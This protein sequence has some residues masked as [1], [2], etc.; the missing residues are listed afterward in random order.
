[1][2]SS[3]SPAD[4]LRAYLPDDVSMLDASQSAATLGQ[5]KAARGFLDAYEARLT[6]HL[7]RLHKAGTSAPA[8]DLHT[9][10]GGVSS[11]EAKAKERRAAAL[12]HAPSMAEKLAAGEIT[13]S[14]ADRLAD[15]TSR[16]DDDTRAAFFAHDELLAHDASRRTPEEFARNCRDL[17]RSIERDQGVERDR[18]QRRETR[19]TTSIDR[20]G[21]YVLNG[22]FHPEA[23]HAIFTAIDTET[24][25]LVKTG[26]D[27]SVDRAA[28]AAEA[29][30]NLVSGGHQAVR[31]RETEVLLLVDEHSLVHG[32]HGDTT[33]EYGDGSPVPVSTAQRLICDAHIVPVIRNADGTVVDIGRTRRLAN[34]AQRRAL[35]AMYRT[36]AFHGCDINFDRCEIHHIVPFELG[37]VTDLRNLLPL[38]S[39]H[40]HVVHDLDWQLELDD[41]RTVTIR[42]RNGAI[43]AVVPLPTAPDG[44]LKPA[45]KPPRRSLEND[46][47]DPD[48]QPAGRPPDQLALLA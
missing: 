32:T 22:R 7:T 24:A 37:G 38:C 31:P 17:I 45:D 48:Q 46:E 42:D 3:T 1:M 6:S 13:G 29:L 47:S 36:C 9:R 21:M 8:A 26:G 35:R 28:V 14:H 19:L 4:A 12:E 43:H 10:D 25:K 11:R 33:S 27:R 41:H 5:L 15:V 18:R 20:D 44:S 39:R 40:H 23:G 34:R 2:I 30:A 16:L